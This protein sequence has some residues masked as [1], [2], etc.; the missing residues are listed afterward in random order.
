VTGETRDP[1]EL[2][3][4]NRFP[5]RR[6]CAHAF[7]LEQVDQALQVAGA[8]VDREAVHVSVIP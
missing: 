2:I 1:V 4:S 8:R 6:L 3:R 7:G 5:L